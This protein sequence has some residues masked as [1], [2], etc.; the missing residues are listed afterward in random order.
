[1]ESREK[2]TEEN[3]SR[4]PITKTTYSSLFHA[5]SQNLGFFYDQA[6]SLDEVVNDGIHLTKG[7]HMGKGSP[8]A[9]TKL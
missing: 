2:M 4:P 5:E 9:M 1:M 6:S 8:R 3:T 7:G